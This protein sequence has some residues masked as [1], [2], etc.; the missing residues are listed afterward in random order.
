MSGWARPGMPLRT[1]P[2]FG[3]DIGV[4]AAVGGSLL[5]TAVMLAPVLRPGYVLFLD[6]VTVPDPVAPEWSQLTA[7]AGLR[8]WPLD[9]V[10]WAWSQVLPTWVLQ[11]AILLLAVLGAGL[12]TGLLLRRWGGVSA[13]AASVLAIV[14]PYVIERLL[15]GQ[16][17]LLLAYAS[18]P[19]IVIASRQSSRPRRVTWTTVASLPAALTPW[20]A[21]VAGAV[22]VSA[23]VVRQRQWREVLTQAGASGAL[24]LVWLLP[25]LL[26]GPG[27][28]DPNG[29]RAF[30]LAD[31]TGLGQFGSALFGAGVWSSAAQ[32][33][34]GGGPMLP[35]TAVILLA[36]SA[37][38]ARVLARRN[39]AKAVALVGVLLVIPGI[40]A[41]LSG[42][43]LS[44]WAESQSVPGFALFRDL[45]RLLAPSMLTLVILASIGLGALVAWVTRGRA[46]LVSIL[47]LVLPVSLAAM[48][49]PAGPGRMHDAYS[50]VWFSAEWEATLG[51]AGRQGAVLTLPWQP[52]RRAEWAPA[53][54]LDPTAKALGSR[55]IGDTT[56]TVA[57]DG[58]IIR[59]TDGAAGHQGGDGEGSTTVDTLRGTLT[60]G[61]ADALPSQLLAS[62]DVTHVIVWKSSPGYVPRLPDDWRQTF[63]GQHF[64]VWSAPGVT[65]R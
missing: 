2:T 4:A 40:T 5:A 48:L 28:A 23:A 65:A 32:A 30:A 19:W 44:W 26:A 62:S 17:A 56:L 45:H 46:V 42:P 38:G 10:M 14:N 6:H 57:R 15:L 53:V 25:A 29:A 41:L 55:V 63:S 51:G 37:V 61:A 49:V 34:G 35:V 47:G 39:V 59:V 7:P 31:E 1:R 24:C 54:F 11:Q 64:E 43:M 27:D 22:A 9:G 20:G 50:P 36:V 21:L 52:L 3:R 18:I 12:G 60:E 58:T 8:A 33:T 16:P 13:F